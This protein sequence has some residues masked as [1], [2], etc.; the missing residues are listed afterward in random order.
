MKRQN[1][2]EALVVKLLQSFEEDNLE[3]GNART[4][5][6][7]RTQFTEGS[8]KAKQVIL[9]NSIIHT[10]STFLAFM[11]LKSMKDVR[12]KGFGAGANAGLGI[13]LTLLLAIWVGAALL[14]RLANYYKYIERATGAY[15]IPWLASDTLIEPGTLYL[16]YDTADNPPAL[17]YL[18][19]VE[20]AKSLICA[21]QKNIHVDIASLANISASLKNELD[22]LNLSVAGSVELKTLIA[23]YPDHLPKLNADTPFVPTENAPPDYWFFPL[24][25]ISQLPSIS[26]GFLLGYLMMGSIGVGIFTALINWMV[27]IINTMPAIAN[28]YGK[29]H[30]MGRIEDQP[31]TSIILNRIVLGFLKNIIPFGLAM[32][33]LASLS[34]NTIIPTLMNTSLGPVTW[35][36]IPGL[37]LLPHTTSTFLSFILFALKKLNLSARI[38]LNNDL[39][40][41]KNPVLKGLAEILGFRYTTISLPLLLGQSPA[42]VAKEMAIG[43]ALGAFG[44]ILIP[45]FDVV[46][47]F[48][49]FVAEEATPLPTTILTAV[50]LAAAL[51]GAILGAESQRAIY[52]KCAEARQKQLIR[53]G[54][55][56]KIQQNMGSSDVEKNNNEQ[57]VVCPASKNLGSSFYMQNTSRSALIPMN[58]ATFFN[59]AQTDS[60][61]LYINLSQTF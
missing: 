17:H 19:R 31:F 56:I 57:L 26:S 23:Q 50:V 53:N 32:T 44:L 33:M 54:S 4:S 30:G 34:V 11:A 46:M 49:E 41:F 24:C 35:G 47:G 8:S 9:I 60:G 58:L 52:E 10:A 21:T 7:G 55:I 16:F 3:L 15:D 36:L 29:E 12:D 14:N 5:T 59:Q 18:I 37:L 40:A 25:C 51:T 42:T 61:K 39:V 22:A 27:N 43:N 38:N 20:K 2:E 28:R 45:S 13:S 1:S 6:V 48:L